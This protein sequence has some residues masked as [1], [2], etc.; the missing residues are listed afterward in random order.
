MISS[1]SSSPKMSS[2]HSAMTASAVRMKMI[3]Q[4]CASI[5]SSTRAANVDGKGQAKPVRNHW[6]AYS[7]GGIPY[8]WGQAAASAVSDD[9]T[10]EFP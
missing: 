8:F 10:D 6:L 3:L 9:V 5:T 4:C 7:I 2:S 1:K